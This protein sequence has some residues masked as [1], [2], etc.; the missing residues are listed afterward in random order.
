[1]PARRL[2]PFG[3]ARSA[4]SSR[5]PS[6]DL[7][8]PAGKYSWAARVR[9]AAG[10]PS[11]LAASASR[12]R[13]LAGSGSLGLSVATR[14]CLR[15]SWRRSQGSPSVR[16]RDI[17]ARPLL[18]HAPQRRDIGSRRAATSS[19]GLHPTVRCGRLRRVAKLPRG[20]LPHAGQRD[21]KRAWPGLC[22][23]AGA[24]SAVRR[25]D[26][27]LRLFGS[28]ARSWRWGFG[29]AARPRIVLGDVSGAGAVGRVCRRV[30]RTCSR[31]SWR[32]RWRRLGTDLPRRP[33]ASTISGAL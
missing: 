9:A 32:G 33:R 19:I 30:R 14:S 23:P 17:E 20:A 28:G 8:P 26:R 5:P 1:M 31:R 27:A 4:P 24:A 25:I 6:G 29:A 21:R 16:T 15:A 2:A 3:R 11:Q 13:W 18:D 10:G 22:F 12:A 7:G